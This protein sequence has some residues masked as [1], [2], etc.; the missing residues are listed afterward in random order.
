MINS[1][2]KRTEMF[3]NGGEVVA[4]DSRPGESCMILKGFAARSHYSRDGS[5]QISAL[6]V[7]GDFVDLHAYLL[8]VMDHGVVAIGPCEVA[9]VSYDSIRRVTE[10]SPHL[11][12]LLWL[13][14]V[15]DG[16][17]Q[18]AWVT[19]LGRRTAEQRMAHLLCE[20]YLRLEAAGIATGNSFHLPLTQSQ[21][22]D[23][24]GLS[25]VHVN[26]KLQKLRLSGLVDWRG[27]IVVI[28]DFADL[29]RLAEFDPTYLSLRVEPR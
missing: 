16:A 19:C 18:R 27:G 7:P 17:I 29:A 10:E 9:Y 14:T 25:V 3:S 28:R 11:G 2:P 8:R 23:L 22:A 15:I 1:L 20:L 12:R 4:E 6:H 21:L 24:L 13:S 26:K 5:R